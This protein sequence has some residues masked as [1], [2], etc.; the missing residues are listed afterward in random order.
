MADDSGVA[1]GQP[2]PG[3]LLP[4]DPSEDHFAVRWDRPSLR[5]RGHGCPQWR[6]M[7]I[8]GGGGHR[9]ASAMRCDRCLTSANGSCVSSLR[10][11][12]TPKPERARRPIEGVCCPPLR[13]R[14][15]MTTRV[16]DVNLRASNRVVFL[17][18]TQSHRAATEIPVSRDSLLVALGQGLLLCGGR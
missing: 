10:G 3:P 5:T 18:P 4:S 14:R 7:M 8:W 1:G 13:L 9:Q 11:T 2:C 6:W 16:G 15:S 17:L 12:P